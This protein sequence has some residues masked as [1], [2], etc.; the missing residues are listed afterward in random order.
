LITTAATMM[1][2]I[3]ALLAFLASASAFVPQQQAVG[4]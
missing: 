2:T 1:K 3:F 4:A